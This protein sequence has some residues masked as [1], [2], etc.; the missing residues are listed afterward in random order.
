LCYVYRY[1]RKKR[2]RRR[3]REKSSCQGAAGSNEATSDS[4]Q[5]FDWHTV[6]AI[7]SCTRHVAWKSRRSHTGRLQDS[8]PFS[9]PF[10]FLCIFQELQPKENSNEWDP[11]LL[12]KTPGETERTFVY[13]R[14]HIDQTRT[15]WIYCSWCMCDCTEF[16]CATLA[17]E[18]T[19]SA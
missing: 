19:F 5:D 13:S 3:N 18:D 9:P 1:P 10:L 4:Q 14:S 11:T 16:L 12:N 8:C 17:R 15:R 2:R 6:N 7:E